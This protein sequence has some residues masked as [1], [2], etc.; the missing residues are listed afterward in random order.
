MTRRV[1]GRTLTIKRT[2]AETQDFGATI[3]LVLT[4]P[5][6]LAIAKG[7]HDWISKRG[8]K[9]TITTPDGTVVAE[10]DGVKGIEIDKTVRALR[11]G[12]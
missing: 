9:V 1:V 10:G 3:I 5:A 11:G 12:K 4:T 7:L 2:S 6:A 8:S